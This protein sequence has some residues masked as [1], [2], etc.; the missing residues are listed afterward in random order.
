[1][2]SASP[3]RK[4]FRYVYFNATLYLIAANVLAFAASIVFP[5]LKAYMAMNPLAVLSGFAWQPVT[6]M[7]AHASLSHLL[8][9]MIGLFF[10]GTAVERSMGSKEFLLFYFLTGTL[11]GLA[12]LGI[13]IAPGAWYT[14]L[15]G[16]SGALFAVLLAF[17]IV[18]PEAKIFLY[19]ILPIRAPVMVVGYAAIEVAS[20]LFSFESSVAHL[21]HLAGFLWAWLYFVLRFGINPA[22]RLFTRRR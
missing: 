11:A 15:L 2:R 9:N 3:L 19:G 5:Q 6:Y 20:Q 1:M 17:A 4:P 22:K 10:F 21:T 7:F 13:Y 14:S 12:S 16:A 8:V 18:N